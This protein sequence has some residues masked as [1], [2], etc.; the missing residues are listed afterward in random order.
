MIKELFPL[1]ELRRL[2]RW[3]AIRRSIGR[4]LF[5]DCGFGLSLG[6][7]EPLDVAG[8][9]VPWYTYPAIHYL[10]QLDFADKTVFEF[11][12]GNST[13][14]WSARASRVTAVEHD[15][16]WHERV[17]GNLAAN[18]TVILE[19]DARLYPGVIGLEGYL[20]DVIVVDGQE[21]RAC[22]HAAL[23]CLAPGGMVILDNADWH[24]RCA[25]VLRD[26]GLI[27][28]DFSGFGPLNGYSWTTSIFLHRE[29]AFKPRG[30]AQPTHGPGA[31]KH[32]EPA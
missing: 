4:I 30:S 26:G 16:A 7:G 9:P 31:L 17:V 11:G 3:L 5:V 29:F 25:E 10:A 12:S 18:A 1:R 6:R 21:R 14:Y 22:C 13:R 8:D 28:V 15:A 19:T 20:Y 27:E 23:R 2:K 32:V 24:H